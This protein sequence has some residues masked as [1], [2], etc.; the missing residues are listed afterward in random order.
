MGQ[1]SSQLWVPLAEEL[2]A[3]L[4]LYSL[5][6]P[7]SSWGAASC[8]RFRWAVNVAQWLP[9]GG[10]EG[11]EFQLLLSLLPLEEQ[12]Q[13]MQYRT[14]PEANTHQ[15]TIFVRQINNKYINICI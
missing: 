15:Y 11:Q 12:Q 1:G 10:A 2:L 8:P 4:S 6:A 9:D 13:V 7:A 14:L 3:E 5:E